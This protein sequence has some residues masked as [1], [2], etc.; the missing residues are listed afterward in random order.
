MTSFLLAAFLLQPAPA[1]LATAAYPRTDPWWTERHKLCLD[2]SKEHLDVA[3][4][5]DSIT[6]GWEGGGKEVWARD[7]GRWKTGNFGFSGDRTQHVLWRLANGELLPAQP[8]V[9]VIMIGTNNSGMAELTPAI[10]AKSISAIVTAIRKGSPKTKILLLDVFPRG[11]QPDTDRRG[12][13]VKIKEELDKIKFDKMVTRLDIGRHFMTEKGV[14]KKELMPDMLHLSPAGYDLWGRA[15]REKID[16]LLGAKKEDLKGGKWVSLF[17]GKTLKGWNPVGGK[18][19]YRVENGTIVGTTSVGGPDTFLRTAKEYTD[20][21]M[22]FEARC[23]TRLNSGIQFR[24][25]M[26]PGITGPQVEIMLSPG[27]SGHF[28]G[29]GMGTGWLSPEP[30]NPVAALNTNW[31]FR[32]D[33]WNSFR[34]VIKG[35]RFRTWIN[36]LPVGD[37]V[38][39]DTLKTH[40]K[41]FIGLQVHGIPEG[42]GPYEAAWRNIKLRE[43]K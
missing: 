38:R 4:L 21:E 39:E 24:S 40:P 26:D 42:Q 30:S 28:W 23:D 6:Q 16:E 20:F 17:D 27:H 3:F 13:V 18:A 10:T 1:D 35:A 33:E 8:K 37:I 41:G 29:A 36:G 15:V 34:V 5:G 7:F 32:N 14:L 9:T 19:T 2:R 12:Y 43:L 22:T 31:V 25:R 11:E